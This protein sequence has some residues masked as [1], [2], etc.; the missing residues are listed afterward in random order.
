MHATGWS[1]CSYAFRG[2]RE[3]SQ[4]QPSL[5][6]ERRWQQVSRSKLDCYLWYPVRIILVIIGAAIC[7]IMGS[8]CIF[9]WT[10]R[11]D[12]GLDATCSQLFGGLKSS[13]NVF[14]AILEP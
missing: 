8:L 5:D 7:I 2:C 11:V 12:T 3:S 9:V 14:Q 6:F 1:S 13:P 4:K 10:I